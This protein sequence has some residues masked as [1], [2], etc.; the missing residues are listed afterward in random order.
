MLTDLRAI[1]KVI[2]PMG[3]LQ[4]GMPLPSLI[5]NR[6]P[7]IVIDLK[8]CFFTIPLQENDRETFAFTIPTLNSSQPVKRF[9]WKVLLER[10]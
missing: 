7:I 6:W 8:D 4:P 1:N 3:C 9:Q 5:P 2:Q 10:M